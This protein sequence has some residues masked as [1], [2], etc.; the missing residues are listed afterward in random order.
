MPL[1]ATLQALSEVTS[2]TAQDPLLALDAEGFTDCCALI[3]VT[4]GT[5]LTATKLQM[6]SALEPREEAFSDISGAL[7]PTL[8]QQGCMAVYCQNFARYLRWRL[9]AGVSAETPLRFAVEVLL[10]RPDAGPES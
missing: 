8:S 3:Y 9:V 6:Q 1:R 2:V 10:K 5:G 4:G 7:S